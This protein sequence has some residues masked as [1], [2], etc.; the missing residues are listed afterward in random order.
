M[1]GVDGERYIPS[2]LTIDEDGEVE[3]GHLAKEAVFNEENIEAYS[4]FKIL[5]TNKNKK[6]LEE[7]GYIK[8][9]PRDISKLYIKE[10]ISIYKQEQ[11]IDKIE[12]MVMSIPEIW[13]IDNKR[14]RRELKDILEDIEDIE[15]FDLKS[16]PICAGA[17]FLHKYK[18]NHKGE[19]FKGHF[20]IFDFGGGTLDITL[21]ESKGDKITVLERTGIGD[22]NNFVGK[23]GV[24]YDIEVV[25]RA[26]KNQNIVID[27]EKLF[28][29][30]LLEFE[31]KKISYSSRSNKIKKA[32]EK[33]EKTGLDKTI[34]QIKKGK[35]EIDIT[36]SLLIEVF[37]ELLKDDIVRSLEEIRKHFDFY[38]IDDKNDKKF[39][40]V[41][42]GGFSNFWLSQKTVMDFF[43]SVTLSDK[44]F[45]QDF[46][47]EDLALAISKG[48]SLLAKDIIVE[49]PI[50]P[51]SIGIIL[52][53]INSDGEKEEVEE[54]LIKK[55]EAISS[56]IN[57]VIYSKKK[58]VSTGKPRLYFYDG[59][60]KQKFH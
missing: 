2:F 44:R 9:T 6:V 25:K 30:I 26:I 14:A 57:K 33:Y 49:E 16:E 36:P 53:R 60:I 56:N 58:I 35:Y 3:V 11:K 1:G 47:K 38:K 21:L 19:S 45:E 54:I 23:A 8:K 48:A 20:I 59:R 15:N 4:N 22:S 46:A 41:L 50:Y 42:V 43:D 51:I 12:K 52:Y 28:L 34:F 37:D 27:D 55:G 40:I 24:A 10:L 5:L 13:I 32:I 17:Y 39:N 31:K 29:P 7:N 18:E